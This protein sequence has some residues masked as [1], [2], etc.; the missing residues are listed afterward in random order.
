MNWYDAIAFANV[1]ST[2]TGREECYANNDDPNV[3]S[4]QQYDPDDLAPQF[5]S[6]YECN[7]FRLLTAAEWEYAARSGTTSEFWTGDGS[8]LGGDIS[9]TDEWSCNA[10]LSIQDGV[11]NPLLRDY[12]WFCGN[13]DNQY[14]VYGTKEVGQKKPNGFGLYDMHG[15][16]I[17]WNSD[18]WGCGVSQTDPYCALYAVSNFVARSARGGYSDGPPLR[19]LASH[20][21]TYTGTDRNGFIGFRLGLTAP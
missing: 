18:Y 16:V 8:S 11:T 9:A 1:L 7:G 3:D 5:N 10:S 13:N 12:A 6:P 21:D 14:G 2:L 4:G 19:M 15:N 17:E 20:H